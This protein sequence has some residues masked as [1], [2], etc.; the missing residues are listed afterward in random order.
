MNLKKLR[1]DNYLLSFWVQG[2]SVFVTDIHRVAYADLKVLYIIDHGIFKQY[3]DE[4]AY[5][6]ALNDG[7]KF[8][9]SKTAFKIY[10]K[11]LKDHCKTFQNFFEFKIK[12]KN[13]ISKETLRKFFVYTIKLCKEYNQ[14]NFERTDKAFALQNKNKMIKKNLVTLS[15]FKDQIRDFMNTVLFGGRSYSNRVFSL[16]SKQ[17]FLPISILENMTQGELLNLFYDKTP[18]LKKIKQ[19]QKAFISIYSRI[20]PYE[21]NEVEL[22][23]KRFKEKIPATGQVTGQVANRG[24][25]SG[26][27]KIIP[28]DYSNFALI[29][30]E[31]SKMEKGDILV[32]ETTAPELIVACRKAGAIVTDMGG[33][34]SHA[35]IVSRELG[36]PCIVGTK[37]ATKILKEGDLV[38]VD[39][40]KGIVRRL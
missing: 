23:L 34:M 31:I 5:Q 32:A 11:N 4:R 27:V 40:N 17:F 36:I 35:A 20:T 30:K 10:Q 2:V 13:Y 9:S 33:L 14:M 16:L 25:I 26:R 18:N 15:K 12:N 6:K 7:V 24:K 3:F 37:V 21:G 29:S 19:R 28:V 8:Y 22:I 39:A 1:K 38:E